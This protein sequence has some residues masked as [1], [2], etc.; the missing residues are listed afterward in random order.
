MWYS[1]HAFEP[2]RNLTRHCA[3]APSAKVFVDTT[4]ILKWVATKTFALGAAAQCRVRFLNGSNAW[5]LYHM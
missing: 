1:F 4:V 3:A 5:K 2:F